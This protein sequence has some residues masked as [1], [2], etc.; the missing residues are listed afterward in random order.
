M[1]LCWDLCRPRRHR[2]QT[3]RAREAD[4]DAPVED[5]PDTRLWIMDALK[6]ARAALMRDKTMSWDCLVSWAPDGGVDYP[7]SLADFDIPDDI[8][9]FFKDQAFAKYGVMQSLMK[10]AL[11][12]GEELGEEL[13]EALDEALDEARGEALGEPV[14]VCRVVDASPYASS[15]CLEFHRRYWIDEA[16]DA[17]DSEWKSL[18]EVRPAALEL[19]RALYPMMTEKYTFLDTKMK[20][21]KKQ[22][23]R[24]R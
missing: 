6:D 18:E 16:M 19:I 17:Y 12:A 10:K 23:K 9:G 21:C 20:K 11:D 13:G 15:P 5:T 14:F 22:S 24:T 2:V 8:P 7:D 4:S 3:L 1:A